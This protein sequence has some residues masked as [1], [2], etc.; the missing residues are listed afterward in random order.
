[1]D[2]DVAPDFFVNVGTDAHALGI[3]CWQLGISY[4]RTFGHLVLMGMSCADV[5][6]LSRWS[7]SGRVHKH[8]HTHTLCHRRPGIKSR[9]RTHELDQKWAILN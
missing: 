2:V 8:T 6:P 4:E 3:S 1:M 9:L 5:G 7:K